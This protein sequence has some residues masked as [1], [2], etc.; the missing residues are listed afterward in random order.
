MDLGLTDKVCVVTGASSGIGLAT[1][2]RLCEERARVL[3][4]A[5]ILLTAIV[6]AL[7]PALT[8]L[9][10]DTL[11]GSSPRARSRWVASTCW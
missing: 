2:R 11:R 7:G 6:A 1:A 4:V 5:L 9:P 10:I 3:F 8:V